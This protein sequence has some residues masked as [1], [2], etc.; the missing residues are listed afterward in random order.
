M[1]QLIDAF[2]YGFY[3]LNKFIL[4]HKFV[5]GE[6][7]EKRVS[8]M[9]IYCLIFI[10][11]LNIL[12]LVPIFHTNNLALDRYSWTGII[13]FILLV[14][15]SLPFYIRYWKEEIDQKFEERWGNEDPKQR[16]KRGWLIVAL[17]INNLVLIP[18]IVI[19]LEH[20]HIM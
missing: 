16:K 14:L 13:V 18:L 11:P 2:D 9:G 7:D 15:E 20:Y 4:A 12:V 10:I 19:I 17:I 8:S 1:E 3:R 6:P 5:R